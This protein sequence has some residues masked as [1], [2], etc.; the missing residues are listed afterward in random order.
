MQLAALCNKLLAQLLQTLFEPAGDQYLV[1]AGLQVTHWGIRDQDAARGG[2]AGGR[3]GRV[4]ALGLS[5]GSGRGPSQGSTSRCL[6]DQRWVD[7]RSYWR[8]MCRRLNADEAET[9]YRKKGSG[10]IS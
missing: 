7:L 6:A 2:R 4:D 10:S 9:F 8:A 1:Q 3:A 5:V